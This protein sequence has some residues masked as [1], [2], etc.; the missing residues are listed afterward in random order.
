MKNVEDLIKVELS[1]LKSIHSVLPKIK[2]SKE[3][4]QLTSIWQDHLDAVNK[5]KKYAG[6]EFQEEESKIGPWGAF[7]SAFTKG[8]SLLG[9]KTV[10]KA[11]KFGEEHGLNEY[12]EAVKN[13]NLD[14][15]LK[16]LI[17]KEILPVQEKHV[18][19]IENY[20]H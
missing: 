9:D 4:E 11:L 20:L 14:P 12:R 1:A 16:E 18:R 8:A 3:K 6:S 2:D 7:S 5:L 10:L 15:N 17:Q 19:T 13:L